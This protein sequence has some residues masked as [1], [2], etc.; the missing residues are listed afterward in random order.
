MVYHQQ[1]CVGCGK[2]ASCI[3]AAVSI[4]KQPLISAV[5]LFLKLLRSLLLAC[6][7]G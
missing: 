4:A 3:R 2:K 7:V 5:I 1:H 6:G